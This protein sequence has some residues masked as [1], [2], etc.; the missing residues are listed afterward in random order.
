MSV[1]SSLERLRAR[2]R[3]LS[4]ARHPLLA[5]MTRDEIYDRGR[6]MAPGGLL[7]ASIVAEGLALRAGMR[8]LDLGCGRGQSSAFLAST[9]HVDVVSIDLWIRAE[10]RRH[11]AESAGLASRIRCL[12]GDITRGLP[13]GLGQ[14][15][16][17]FALQSFH[18]FGARRGMVRYLAS[19]LAAGGRVAI[20][21]TCF[22]EEPG[23]LAGVFA[24]TGGWRAEYGKYHAPPWWAERFRQSGAFDVER[25]EE[26]LDGDVM[27]E[28]D[29]LYRGDRDGWTDEFLSRN[30]WLIRQILQSQ[31]IPPTLTHFVLSARRQT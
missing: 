16:A 8:V 6:M 26:L 1:T 31:I 30:A 28:D 2:L 22:R 10:E 29:L 9:F 5:V 7:L 23:E 4:A 25:C 27:W 15:D 12:E 14:F 19:L 24:D 13:A 20:G 11:A 18:S 3:R 17:V 21:Q